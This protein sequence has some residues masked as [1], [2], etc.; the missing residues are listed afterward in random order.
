MKK[1]ALFLFCTITPILLA[2]NFIAIANNGEKYSFS[3][4][5]E[6]LAKIGDDFDMYQ[7]IKDLY[8]GLK[9]DVTT[10][11]MQELIDTFNDWN[12]ESGWDG[13]LKGLELFGLGI[14]VLLQG[15]LFIICVAVLALLSLLQVVYN[16][17]IL[18]IQTMG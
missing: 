11:Q 14:V 17:F 15:L 6:A 7:Q 2:V 5:G 4:L 10:E 1:I 9:L 12:N 16:V 8:Q 18:L 3:N 13:I